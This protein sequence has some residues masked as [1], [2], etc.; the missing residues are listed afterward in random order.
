MQYRLLD[1]GIDTE[2]QRVTRGEDVLPV[3]G[4]SFRLLAFLLAQ[5][6]R[7]VGFDE[8]IE[9]V[10]A[11]A[12]VGEETVTQRI[13]LLRQAMG[14]EGRQP[15]YIRSVRGR[16]YQL[17]AMPRIEGEALLP[18]TTPRRWPWWLAVGVAGA[19]AAT[20]AAYVWM[21]RAERTPPPDPRSPLLVRASY[22]AA[23]GQRDNNERAIELYTDALNQAPLDRDAMLGLSRAMS[24]R[25]CL[26]NG[27][28]DDVERG[29]EL[30]NRLLAID[31]VRATA[32]SAKGYAQDCAG[33]IDEAMAAY[34]HAVQLDP[35]DDATR[36]SLAYL[37]QEKGLLA[38]ALHEN[39]SMRGDG[40]KVRFREVQI[41]RELELLGFTANAQMRLERSF[42]LYPDNVFSN[43]AWPRSLFLQGRFAQATSELAVAQGRNTPHVELDLLSGE[44]ALQ[45]GDRVA[46][47]AAFQHAAG[48]R[49]LASLP[50]TLVGIYAAAGVD[51]AWIAERIDEFNHQLTGGTPWPSQYLELAVLELSRDRK[52]AAVAAINRAID[53]GYRDQAYLQVSPLFIKLAGDPGF[54][55]ALDRIAADVARQ[56]AEV[57]NASWRPADLP[58]PSR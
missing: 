33:R 55:H 58:P 45:R 7:V 24:A 18:E 4:L 39:L 51:P 1:L 8:L 37:H 48:L 27:D 17:A 41:G 26:Y 57:L 19:F 38:Q 21:H 52:T 23:I 56:R 53:A 36:A 28:R 14:D 2:R 46:A 15:R 9:K 35:A 29:L 10:W 3:S 25:A 20:C 11:P 30:A 43:L 40:S 47:D 16:G 42:R 32:W 54:A 12:V 49:P 6:D 34:A 5:G 31:P 22:Y 44:L 13:K 50:T